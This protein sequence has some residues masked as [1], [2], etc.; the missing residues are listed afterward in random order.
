MWLSILGT[1]VVLLCGGVLVKQS[2]WICE[3]E[4]W[5]N[6]SIFKAHLATFRYVSLGS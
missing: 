3:Y 6:C 2:C 5:F 1:V 4:I